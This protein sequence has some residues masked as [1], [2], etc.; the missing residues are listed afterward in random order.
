MKLQDQHPFNSTIMGLEDLYI[1]M[2]KKS[3]Y[4]NSNHIIANDCT[5]TTG[6]TY[7]LILNK[8]EANLQ[9]LYVQLI[10]V[11]YDNV[12]LHIMLKELKSNHSITIVH[13]FNSKDECL[14][15]LIDWDY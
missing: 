4:I 7:V 10:D 13:D 2:G 8:P 15:K 12:L 1:V 14:W 11:Y 6:R 3:F 9:V 5:I